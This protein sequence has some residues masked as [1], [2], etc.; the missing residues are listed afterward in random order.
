MEPAN[1]N[2][3][4]ESYLQVKQEL[5]TAQRDLEKEKAAWQAVRNSLN[6]KQAKEL[7]EQFKTIFEK[8]DSIYSTPHIELQDLLQALQGL[9]HKGASARIL[10]NHELGN[11]NLGKLVKEIHYIT[12]KARLE[13]A[14]EFIRITIVADA[15]LSA[16]KAYAGNGGIASLEWLCLA[17]AGGIGE[18][19]EL[20]HPDQYPY[21]YKIFP[22]VANTKITLEHPFSLFIAGLRVCPEVADWQQKMILA[23]M[24]FGFSPCMPDDLYQSMI[25]SRLATINITWLT[26]LFPYEEEQLKHYIGVLKP[27]VT[28]AAIKKFVNAFTSNNKTRKHFRAFF[29]RGAHW[30]LQHILTTA[31]EVIFA[32]V[33]GNEQDMLVPFLKN[34]KPAILE[35][36]DEKGNTLLHQ[37]VLSR[38]LAENTIQLL[39]NARLP[40]G[41]TNKEGLTPLD[42]AVKNNRTN[43][44]KWL[45]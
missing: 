14:T 22:W 16:Q 28:Q 18:Y 6:E 9:V 35:L 26:T 10:S 25:F 44:I 42:L 3:P 36:R 29:S 17:L 23:L 8:L 27:N 43:L 34:C 40:A 21:C 13:I 12:E 31:P 1:I 45:N 15:D 4:L 11:Y 37:A 41:A 30:L 20:R 39:R 7:D 5:L 32:L 19:T 2:F 33:K 24:V 38:G